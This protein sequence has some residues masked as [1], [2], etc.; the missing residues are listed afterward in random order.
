MI[1]V[2][3][4]IG[5]QLFLRIEVEG[6]GSWSKKRGYQGRVPLGYLRLGVDIQVV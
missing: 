6:G 3:V 2:A 5:Y 1:V 4:S